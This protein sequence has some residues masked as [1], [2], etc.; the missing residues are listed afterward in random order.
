[1][2]VQIRKFLF[3]DIPL[4][5]KWI[6]DPENNQ[7]LHYDLPLEYGKTCAWFE[8]NKDRPDRYDA[9]ILA[10]GQPVGLI[11]LL[12]IG[13]GGSGSSEG[14]KG[15]DGSKHSIG[16]DGSNEKKAEYYISMGE[17][18]Y[19]GKGIAGKASE[20]LLEYAFRRL[21]LGRVYLYT[22]IGNEK[23]QR[24]FGRIGFGQKGLA[25]ENLIY[26]GR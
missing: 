24:L 8:K 1:M 14:S 12:S 13:S 17:T 2:Q 11:G 20:L 23:A 22:E 4:K 5:I 10:D 19:K 9:V 3:E 7:F 26:Q 6:N 21:R 25:K 18:A 15:S 16:S